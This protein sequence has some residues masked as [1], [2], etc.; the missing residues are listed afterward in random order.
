MVFAN[1]SVAHVVNLSLPLVTASD[2]KA[3][4]NTQWC[5]Q[6]HN[7]GRM[8]INQ[9]LNLRGLSNLSTPNRGIELSL[10]T[11]EIECDT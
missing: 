9:Y 1:R 2:E 7:G 8:F 3:G 11:F 4:A 5:Q 6:R 10:N